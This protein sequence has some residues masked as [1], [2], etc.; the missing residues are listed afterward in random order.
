MTN[1]SQYAAQI[2]I[3]IYIVITFGYSVIEKLLQWRESVDFYENHFRETSLKNTI[4]FLLKVVI[5]LE[6]I[7]VI[8][9]VIGLFGLIVFSNKEFGFYGLILAALTLIGLMFG[10]RIAKDYAG[11]MNI[12]VYF[13]LTIIGVFMLQ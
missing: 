2:F 13:I 11:A 7:T 3:L 12:T 9:C 8:I 4:P 5:L 6:T 10:Q 1:T